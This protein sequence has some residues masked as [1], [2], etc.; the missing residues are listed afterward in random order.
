MTPQEIHAQFK[1]NPL[2]WGY[3]YLSHHFTMPSP[4]FHLSI[5]QTVLRNKK[6]VICAPRGHSKSSLLM[7]LFPIWGVCFKRFRNIVILQANLEKAISSLKTIKAEFEDNELIK[8]TYRIKFSTDTQNLTA[9]RHPDG[10]ETQIV[11]F[12]MEQMGKIRGTKFGAY[13]PDAILCHEKGSKIFDGGRLIDISESR[14]EKVEIPS[15]IIDVSVN[16]I[17]YPEGVTPEH[18]F[19]CRKKYKFYGKGS[20]KNN[21][22]GVWKFTEPSWIMAKDLTKH[23]YIGSRI[24]HTTEKFGTIEYY[25]RK[26]IRTVR[27]KNGMI[28]GT[29]P[30]DRVQVTPAYFNDP[31][32]WWAMGLWWGDGHR[33]KGQVCWTM[34]NKYP[35]LKNRLEGFISRNGACGKTNS[36][37]CQVFIWSNASLA[38]WLHSWYVGKC[39]KL[40]PRWVRRLPNHYMKEFC[41]GYIQSDG[42]IDQENG[43]AR[44]T[45]V[46]YEGLLAYSQMLARLGVCGHIRNGIDGRRIEILGKMCD[47]QKKYDIYMSS[48]LE[49]LGVETRKVGRYKIKRSFIDKGFIW[50]KVESVGKER[51]G[52]VIPITTD[53]GEYHSP[54]G[55]SHNCDDLETDELVRTR[56]L[57]EELHRKYKDAV[58]PAVDVAADFR[59]VYIDTM[60]HYD[61]QLA[62]MMGAEMYTD[63]KKL[64]FPAIWMDKDGNER[65]L[66]EE[67]FPL[68]ELKRL[69][70]ED[71]VAFAKEYMGD[72][73]TGQS[74]TFS[75]EDFRR[76][77][78]TSDEYLLY[79]KDG[80]IIS[81]GEL[82]NCKVAIGYDLA[83]EDKRRHDCT[84]IVPVFLTPNNEILVDFYINE[85][86]LRPDML[87]EYVFNLDAKYM[88][89]VK[90]VIY[91]GFE[92]G[93]YEKVA[94]WLLDQ[95]KRKRGKFPIFKDVS[96]VTDKKERI[97]VPLQPRYANHAIFHRKD[98]GDLESQLMRFPS[99]THDDILDALT[100]A[101]RI[102]ASDVPNVKREKVKTQT[103]KFNELRAMFT[104]DKK[105]D[106]NFRLSGKKYTIPATKSFAV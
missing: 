2:A 64:F 77:A 100:I 31:D 41:L 23:H 26:S 59:I 84:S 75:A 80:S 95:E 12:G 30:G 57:R 35:D 102:L 74:A 5:L 37:G 7:T 68:K 89:I 72:P 13:R 49:N 93:K 86:G 48:K 61:S 46:H 60:K 98:M 25:D 56:E 14:F 43:C 45:S 62:K 81:R 67:R 18:R 32:F 90:K 51:D 8:K 106:R 91:H 39:K 40:P 10:F 105:K 20:H 29:L 58:E 17:P 28:A 15:K 96:W 9:F 103:D 97:T 52:L 33:T 38:K 79:D 54:I 47:T 87:M 42:F 69:E 99:G 21:K 4:P 1:E 50:R 94:K 78:V 101:V 53:T 16:G 104:E 71:P 92:K 3:Y 36:Q 27:D 76:W 63:Y 82:R 85:K 70:K 88:G 11:C 24:D 55:L 65:A 44:V 22:S 73:V 66:W 6:T 83:W 34:A 19:Y